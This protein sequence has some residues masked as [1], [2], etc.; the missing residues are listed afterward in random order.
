MRSQE[1]RIL[2]S[3]LQIF[4]SRVPTSTGQPIVETS[5]FSQN[6]T[7]YRLSGTCGGKPSFLGMA[8][9]KWPTH[10]VDST[11]FLELQPPP[12]S[13]TGYAGVRSQ[14]V[15]LSNPVPMR[16]SHRQI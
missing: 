7:R 12:K 15:C 6:S 16:S 13:K 9:G 10:S 11:H 2:A 1:S 4:Q 5:N 8:H 14:Q 3:I